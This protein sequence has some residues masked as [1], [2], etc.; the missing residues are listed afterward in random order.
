MKSVRRQ[1]AAPPSIK[2]WTPQCH[3][4]HEPCEGC[5]EMG[6]RWTGW[7]HANPATEAL[8]EMLH[9]GPRTV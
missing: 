2:L 3:I 4:A 1:P 6:M 5:A 8:G 7:T 9:M